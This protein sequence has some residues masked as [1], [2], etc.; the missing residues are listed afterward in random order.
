MIFV[1]GKRCISLLQVHTIHK[2]CA[3]QRSA[4]HKEKGKSWD[5]LVIIN[6]LFIAL[7]L[8]LFVYGLFPS[9]TRR[10]KGFRAW[11]EEGAKSCVCLLNPR[12]LGLEGSA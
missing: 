12:R 10:T 6:L 2:I 3:L 1:R 9:N 4:K 7:S 5:L 11:S 8:S